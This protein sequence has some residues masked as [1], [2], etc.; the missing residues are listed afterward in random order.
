MQRRSDIFTGAFCDRHVARMLGENIRIDAAESL[1]FVVFSGCDAT[2]MEQRVGE[3]VKVE[4]AV[5]AP[6]D[7]AMAQVAAAGWASDEAVNIAASR[8]ANEAA[9]RAANAGANNSSDE[10]AHRA[11]N[12]VAND[13][14]NEAAN[15]LQCPKPAELPGQLGRPRF[16]SCQLAKQAGARHWRRARFVERRSMACHDDEDTGW[17][18]QR[19][20]SILAFRAVH[21][22]S[23]NGCGR[24]TKNARKLRNRG[25][26]SW[27]LPPR[28]PDAR[29]CDAAKLEDPARA[30]ARWPPPGVPKPPPPAG[31]VTSWAAAARAE[32]GDVELYEGKFAE[33][34]IGTDAKTL[35]DAVAAASCMWTPVEKKRLRV[36]WGKAIQKLIRYRL[37]QQRVDDI[38]EILGEFRGLQRLA[39]ITG[40]SKKTHIKEVRNKSGDL[41]HE[42]SI[43]EVFAQFYEDLYSVSRQGNRAFSYE[44]CGGDWVPDFTEDELRDAIQEMQNGRSCHD[45]GIAAEMVKV[46]CPFLRELILGTFNAILNTGQRL[47]SDWMESRITARKYGL[48]LRMGKTVVLTNAEERPLHV[49]RGGRD[50]RALQRGEAEKYLGRK[51]TF[52]ACHETEL[53]NIISAGWASFTK[54]KSVLCDRRLPLADRAQLFCACVAPAVAVLYAAGTWTLKKDQERKLQSAQRR[55]LRSMVGTHRRLDEGWVEC[56][57]RA[58]HACLGLAEKHHVEEWTA[59]SHEHKRELAARGALREDTR[60]NARPLDWIPRHR[61]VSRR[62]QAGQ[63]KRGAGGVCGAAAVP[64]APRLPPGAVRAVPG[65]PASAA[66]PGARARRA[67]AATGAG[68]AEERL[69]RWLPWLAA[70]ATACIAG[71]WSMSTRDDKLPGA[72]LLV[73]FAA[74]SGLMN[75]CCSG[76]PTW[77]A[78]ASGF[79]GNAARF[80]GELD[81]GAPRQMMLEGRELAR[82]AVGR[83]D[84]STQPSEGTSGASLASCRLGLL[85]E[86]DARRQLSGGLLLVRVRL[87]ADEVA[88][89]QEPPPRF[90]LVPRLAYLPFL[91]GCVSEHFKACLPPQLGQ[92]Y[93]IWFDYDGIPLRWHHPLGVL[94]DVLVGREV[95]V[96]LDLTAHFRGGS[97]KAGLTPFGGA[98]ALQRVV[99]SSFRQAVFLQRGCTGPFSRLPRA[100]QTRLWEAIAGFGTGHT[101]QDTFTASRMEQALKR[102][103]AAQQ[104]LQCDSLERCR[105]LAVRIHFYGPP[106]D[107]LLLPA[108]PLEDDGSLATVGGLLQR[109]MP[110]LFDAAGRARLAQG[111]APVPARLADGVEVLTHGVL[112]PLD[113]PLYWLALHAAYLDLFVHL[114]VRVPPA[115]LGL[116]PRA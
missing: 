38:A 97:S 69:R 103:A 71:R 22:A 92:P 95:P 10:G 14:T 96:P 109:A 84:Q 82:E 72:R 29:V 75:G 68:K 54:L 25:T 87:A 105:S 30:P 20:Q 99:M 85:V 35:K 19:E 91:F 100:D 88:S 21:G 90:F 18:W 89:L 51:L 63:K 34:G 79:S 106:H 1:L 113:T 45:K 93:E 44:M 115:L 101:P 65:L 32:D 94:C 17:I 23:A 116:G 4:Y 9:N 83:S 26:G 53:T 15:N 27:A 42:A 28:R 98:G 8:A 36:E 86:E 5:A 78:D 80:R 6:V 49:Q 67:P 60:W 56:I 58:T 11:A 2:E 104:Q 39:A 59:L 16:W 107:A 55:M 12:T 37:S 114:V 47:P 41:E 43:A 76:P 70:L 108:A 81:R 61:F 66:V 31:L 7:S 50:V 52:D 74:I 110:P 3:L 24:T 73:R 33:A 102:Y 46:D 62:S 77:T 112:V 57:R 40:T 64:P 111:L 13:G 48:K